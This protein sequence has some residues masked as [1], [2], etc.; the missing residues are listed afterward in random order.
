VKRHSEKWNERYARTSGSLPEPDILLTAHRE[1]LTLGRALDLACGTGSNALFLAEQGYS[2]D[3]VDIS[4]AALSG[5]S[6]EARRRSLPVHCVVADLDYFVLP[7]CT[8]DLVAIF[9]FFDPRLVA[10]ITG[11]LR[12]GGTLFYATYNYRHTS[13]KPGFN[14]DYLVP[15]GGLTNYFAALSIVLDEPET[16]QYANV[17]RLIAVKP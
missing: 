4:F 7:K 15:A 6:S 5:L 12:K 3:A 9:Y 8:Y 14:K 2:V 10:S 1:L 13:V 16:G 17:S 11:C